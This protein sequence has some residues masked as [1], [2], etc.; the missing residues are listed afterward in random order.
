LLFPTFA[1][2]FEY[3]NAQGNPFGTWGSTAYTQAGQLPL[4]Q[5]VSF[6]GIWGL[7]FLMSWSASTINWAWEHN[8][9]WETIQKGL[10][11]YLLLL[12]TIICGGGIR[13]ATA[14]MK[15]TFRAA[16]IVTPENKKLRSL[17]EPVFFEGKQPTPA[18]WKTY[19]ERARAVR[20][21][22]LSRTAQAAQ[23]GAKVI[24]WAEAQAPIQQKDQKAFLQKVQSLAKQH[25][26]YIGATMWLFR[27]L[28]IKNKKQK[29]TENKL[30]FVTPQGKIGFE[31]LKTIPVPGPELAMVQKGDGKMKTINTPFGTIG[32]MICFDMDFPHLVKQASQKQVDL[33]IVPASD[34]K[35]ITPH[36][37]RIASFRAI[38]NG[39]SLLRVTDHGESA[40]YDS[41]GRHLAGMNYFTTNKYILYTDIPM[42]SK[43]WTPYSLL[44]DLLGMLCFFLTIGLIGWGGWHTWQQRKN[45]TNA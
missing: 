23:A 7:I 15:P 33:L 25:K 19:F 31:Y 3:F 10:L 17:I 37:T 1:V 8:F 5:S 41:Y 14:P 6:A 35:D 28:D 18:L 16:G 27:H 26:V 43:A 4:I 20:A 44:G 9:T 12:V 29:M 42:T 34:W 38:E 13:L 36:H 40:S 22:L 11:T 21:D 32:A 39:F 24:V 2:A 45:P 30:V